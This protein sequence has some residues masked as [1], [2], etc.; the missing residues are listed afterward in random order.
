M[1]KAI[2]RRQALLTSAAIALAL[3]GGCQTT[4]PRNVDA[5]A[6]RVADPA[7]PFSVVYIAADN[8]PYCQYFESSYQPEWL[9]SAERQ[10][11]NYRVVRVGFYQDIT[12]DDAWPNDL[13]WLRDQ[14]NLRRGTPRF[15]LVKG[16]EVLVSAFGTNALRNKVLPRLREELA[17][18]AMVPAALGRSAL[19]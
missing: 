9:A 18:T 17:R 10:K 1:S 13:I 11:V 6:D 3:L 12:P 14:L 16:R 8:C 15:L 2:A 5:G 7:R 19:G 4:G